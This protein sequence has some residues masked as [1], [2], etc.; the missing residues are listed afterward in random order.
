MFLNPG[1]TTISRRSGI[2]RSSLWPIH[3]LISPLS[4]LVFRT[5][6]FVIQRNQNWSGVKNVFCDY[7]AIYQSDFGDLFLLWRGRRVLS[8]KKKIA[9]IGSLDHEIIFFRFR[10]GRVESGFLA[11]PIW[12]WSENLEHYS[13]VTKISGSLDRFVWQLLRR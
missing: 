2:Y 4:R 1:F 11:D 13:C 3:I 8:N 7:L 5:D 12:I 10:S 9:E 6:R